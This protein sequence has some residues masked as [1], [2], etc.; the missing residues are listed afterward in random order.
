MADFLPSLV[1]RLLLDATA[2]RG[3]LA[4][5]TTAAKAETS[6]SATAFNGLATVG[7]AAFLGL[8]GAAVIGGA[9][10]VH[11]AGDY[12][13]A[14]NRL[15]TSAGESRDAIG[16][17]SQ[18]MLDM[19]GQVGFSAMDLARAMYTVESAGQHGVAGLTVLRA[20]AEGAKAENADLAKV[21]DAVTSAL[22]DYH[23]KA[24]DATLVTTQMVAAV[25][26][27]K[28]IFEGMTGSLHSVLPVASAAHISL[29]D[30]L[31]DVASMT[32]HGMSADQVTQNL[33]HTI[34]HLQKTTAP[35]NKELALLGINAQQLSVDLGSKGLSGTLMEISDAIEKRMGPDGKVILQMQDALKGLPAPVQ[36][37]GKEVING[38][39]SLGDFTKAAKGLNVEQAG[40]AHAF[41]TLMTS[42]H[43]IGSAQKS[44]TEIAQTYASA[45]AAATGDATTLQVALM[46]TGEN[47]A[48]THGA[49]KAV[50]GA[51]T[52]AGDHVAGWSSIQATFNQRLDRSSAAA[53][54]LGITIGTA[55][56]P[57]VERAMDT[58]SAW[59]GYLAT[60]QQVAMAL[61]AVVGGALA[62]AIGAYIL[63]LGIA[64]GQTIIATARTIAHTA[65]IV[66]HAAIVRGQA[67]VAFIQLAAQ[68][69]ILNA[70]SVTSIGMWVAKTAATIA[71]TVATVAHGV[72]MGVVTVATGIATAAQW[73]WNVAMAANPIGFVILAV[74]AL[75]AGIIW[76][77]QNVGWF[78]DAVNAAWDGIKR[79]GEWLRDTLGPII[80]AIGDAIGAAASKLG[81]FISGA[82][83]IP[84]LGGA[85]GGAGLPMASGGIV[86][87]PTMALLGE[88][89]P[90][91]VVPLR[92]INRG[93]QAV[94][95]AYQADQGAG[96]REVV[97]HTHVYLGNE[98]LARITQRIG[99]GRL[100]R[101]LATT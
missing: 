94:A 87:R 56:I 51:T 60:H 72:A 8:A 101:L 53:G 91:M 86:T 100:G 76:A 64:A 22:Q 13:Q 90:E 68:Y 38:T 84:V 1:G 81:G 61:A 54:A 80:K 26:Q 46:L 82:K 47:A 35:Q 89:G 70:L 63:Q 77:Y 49:I 98:E 14:T 30:I 33:A 58:G 11:M 59:A 36:Q 25:G 2:F 16:L 28:T 39:A 73:A 15:V 85:L 34:E 66:I 95:N 79:F 71:S 65:A 12:E 42:T 37:L 74:A 18:G 83:N 20:A 29:S 88:A 62:I 27:G 5:A 19:A 3:E 97:I 9:A 57:Y 45:L 48:Y 21:A 17:V 78:R 40:L 24:T 4:A 50:S 69:G 43:G 93:S 96:G 41:A 31:G 67:V 10:A 6:A 99:D 44:G 23:L 92:D 52:E 75:V 7:K 55:L 32:V